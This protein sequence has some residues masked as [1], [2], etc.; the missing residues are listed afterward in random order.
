MFNFNF[1]TALSSV[2]GKFSGIKDGSQLSVLETAGIRDPKAFVVTYSDK[3]QNY[4]AV[5]RLKLAF[6]NVP[7]LTRAADF[8][9]YWKAKGAVSCLDICEVRLKT[10]STPPG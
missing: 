6:P 4:K 9:Q 8:R 7:I 10:S 3:E 5:E 2:P 1:N